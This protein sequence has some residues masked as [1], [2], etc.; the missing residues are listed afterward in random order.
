MTQNRVISTIRRGDI[1]DSCKQSKTTRNKLSKIIIIKAVLICSLLLITQSS[2]AQNQSLIFV[3]QSY[4]LGEVEIIQK[5]Y[6]PP[7]SIDEL[8]F[9]S[10]DD[11]PTSISR[12]SGV[13]F[14]QYGSRAESSI[15]IRGI[16]IR[17]VPVFIDGIPVYSPYDGYLDLSNLIAGTLYSVDINKGY[18]PTGLSVNSLGGAINF[19]SH[20][21]AR[22][23]EFRGEISSGSGNSELNAVSLGS[24]FGK[25]YFTGS[26]KKLSRDFYRLSSNFD[27]TGRFDGE[28]DYIRNN[29]YFN[30]VQSSIKIGFKPDKLDEYSLNYIYHSSSKGSPPYAGFDSNQRLRYWQWPVWK[31]NSLYFIGKKRFSSSSIGKFRLFYDDFSNQL[32]SYD[33]DKYDTQIRRYAFNSF[34]DDYSMGTNADLMLS[35]HKN[36][37]LKISAQ[38]KLDNH[39]E[40]NDNEPTRHFK[41]VTSFIG[42]ENLLKIG[43]YLSAV[44]SVGYTYRSAVLA[45]DY[46]SIDSTIYAMETNDIGGLIF[47]GKIIYDINDKQKISAGLFRKIRLATM[48]ERFSYRAGIGIPNPYLQPEKSIQGELSHHGNLSSNIEIKSAL[49]YSDLSNAILTKFDTITGL[50]QTVNKSNAIIYGLELD[51]NIE[52]E[53]WLEINLQYTLQ[54]H[55][56]KNQAPELSFTHIPENEVRGIFS[57]TP[58]SNIVLR[59]EAIYMSERFSTSYGTIASAFFIANA[60]LSF[61]ISKKI[62]LN[63]GLNN[64]F[65]KNYAYMEGYP[66]PGRNFIGSIQFEL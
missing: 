55:K 34:Y 33:D 8:E 22:P 12:N 65:D 21:P 16:D 62:D 39:A 45:E 28:D 11:P 18:T 47:Q 52:A 10:N 59:T 42:I 29:S 19:I 38:I 49:F 3:A 46:N 41:D 44:G 26:Y 15:A 66:E 25:V 30:K 36:N 50:V 61:A 37:F 27:T 64:I 60:K 17:G 63:L 9:Q 20:T 48:K 6:A 13:S 31:K 7:L 53:H 57:I 4:E 32:S 23:L 40:Y 51:L 35:V 1:K 56:N 24:K 5:D 58:F 2:I 54:K 43:N 14:I